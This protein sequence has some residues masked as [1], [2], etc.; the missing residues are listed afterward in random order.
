MGNF[1]GVPIVNL[2]QDWESEI[3]YQSGL[4]TNSSGN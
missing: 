4:Q 1:I 2:N 3:A